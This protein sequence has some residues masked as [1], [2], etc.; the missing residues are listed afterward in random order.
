MPRLN[1]A[2]LQYS[3]GLV[4]GC[5]DKKRAYSSLVTAYLP[6]EAQWEYACR[7]GTTT[8]YFSGNEEADLARVGWYAGNSGGRV[9]ADGELPAN[10]FGVCDMHGNV[11]EWCGDW[12]G[13]YEPNRQRDPRGAKLGSARGLRGGSFWNDA[14]GCRSAYRNRGDPVLRRYRLGFRVA[15]PCP[16][17]G[18]DD[19]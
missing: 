19:R 7:A 15:Q 4:P 12:I 17:L 10:P 9:H 13:A 16:S 11:L 2:S 8:R 1:C 14:D 18:I 3:G 5:A 6:T